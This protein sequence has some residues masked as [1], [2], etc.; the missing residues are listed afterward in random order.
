MKH[1]TEDCS[2]YDYVQT[3]A[4]LGKRDQSKTETFPV[5]NKGVC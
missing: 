1:A 2:D 3:T 5:A 4:N